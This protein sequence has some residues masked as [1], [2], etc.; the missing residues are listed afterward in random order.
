MDLLAYVTIATYNY[1]LWRDSRMCVSSNFI[2]FFQLLSNF[3]QGSNQ[4]R[5][6]E[7][8]ELFK[9]M[10]IG[11]RWPRVS[12]QRAW[13]LGLLTTGILRQLVFCQSFCVRAEYHGLLTCIC[14]RG[15]LPARDQEPRFLLCYRKEPQ[16]ETHPLIFMLQN[17][18]QGRIY[19]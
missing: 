18:D 13:D 15:G 6:S 19:Q 7:L 3:L 2:Q 10:A 5:T 16:Q 4:Q 1:Y 17:V 9:H 14:C 8:P 11:R 12:I